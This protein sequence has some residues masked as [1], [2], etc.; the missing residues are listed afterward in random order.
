MYPGHRDGLLSPTAN[1]S[2]ILGTRL[3][4]DQIEVTEAW[5]LPAGKD[6]GD[7]RHVVVCG[8]LVLLDEE[9]TR[10]TFPIVPIRWCTPQNGFWGTGIAQELLGIQ[11]ELNN[12]LRT[13]QL[14]M[15]LH[16]IPK[17][18]LQHGSKVTKSH[19]DDTMGGIIEYTG[20]MPE[21]RTFQSVAPEIFRQI[22]DLYSKAYQITG[23]SSL[24]AQA[25]KPVGLNSGK[26]L[27]EFY[28]IETERFAMV[29]KQ[30]EQFFLACAQQVVY[31]AKDIA[32]REG[33]YPV[34]A[35]TGRKVQKVD[36]NDVDLQDDDYVLQ[37]YPTNMLPQHPA[38][39]LEM[40]Q[41][42]IGM[43]ALDQATAIKLLDFPDLESVMSRKNAPYDV[44]D[45]SVEAM[46]DRGEY[47]P[48]E[49]FDNLELALTMVQERYQHARLMG[50]DEERLDLLRTYISQVKDLMDQAQPPGGGGQA[51]GPG[52]QPTEGAP[53]MAPPM[54][55]PGITPN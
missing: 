17:W 28:D 19:L 39:R 40:I 20:K 1:P 49:A 15:R 11:Y 22:E 3:R 12:C 26:S 50:Y 46:L 4:S 14:S 41:E 52:G 51:A 36:W 34:K 9:W 21:L 23:I 32:T 18:L 13:A 54:G 24:S 2:N 55:P 42:L 29:V 25:Q 6:A 27:R 45:S 30:W 44:I 5:H 37:I 35:R 33:S 7:G 16:A 43:G 8:D 31:L 38:G 48:P 47:A 53:P 10:D